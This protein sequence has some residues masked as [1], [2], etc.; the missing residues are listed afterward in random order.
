MSA[1]IIK[2]YNDLGSSALELGLFNMLEVSKL[3]E[4][5]IELLETNKNI[6]FT[7]DGAEE[8][9][10]FHIFAKEYDCCGD[11]KAIYKQI[12]DK[13]CELNEIA[14]KEE[15]YFASIFVSGKKEEQESIYVELYHETKEYLDKCG[16]YSMYFTPYKVHFAGYIASI[17]TIDLANYTNY[18]DYAYYDFN[19]G[20]LY[21]RNNI[22]ET[23]EVY[24]TILG[25]ITADVYKTKPCELDHKYEHPQ[26]DEVVYMEKERLYFM[27]AS[28]V[29]GLRY[30]ES[31]VLHH[32]CP[33]IIMKTKDDKGNETA[34]IYL[35]DNLDKQE[36]KEEL[37]ELLN[38]QFKDTITKLDLYVEDIEGNR[39][40]GISYIFT[41][42]NT[43]EKDV[44][45]FFSKA[46]KLLVKL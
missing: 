32:K 10:E 34:Y 20:N 39:H 40:N 16:E 38:R 41:D 27:N 45:S 4:Q 7:V 24:T 2:F 8:A 30:F 19:T 36:V 9:T 28:D 21:I 29:Q 1:S 43:T 25:D 11:V 26:T 5:I 15:G 17:F 33:Y 44:R 42:T 46:V 13:L 23:I 3:E 6:R 22:S 12:I 18:I 31:S 37:D 14:Y 35:D